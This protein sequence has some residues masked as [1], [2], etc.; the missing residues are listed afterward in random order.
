MVVVGV[1]FQKFERGG[2]VGNEEVVKIRAKNRPLRDSLVDDPRG[3][4]TAL[5]SDRACPTPQVSGQPAEDI[6]MKVEGGEWIE[7]EGV[8]DGVKRF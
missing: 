8:I 6:G 7:E 5:I 4:R 3:C 1:S 2:E